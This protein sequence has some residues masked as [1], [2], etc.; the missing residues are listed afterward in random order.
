MSTAPDQLEG[1]LPY[2]PHTYSKPA[3]PG[4]ERPDRT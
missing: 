4:Q 3:C 2:L 1:V